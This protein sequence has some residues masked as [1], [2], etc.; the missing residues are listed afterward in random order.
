MTAKV[1]ICPKKTALRPYR[2]LIS[3]IELL[4]SWKSV[5]SNTTAR[6]ENAN[7]NKFLKLVCSTCNCKEIKNILKKDK[8]NAAF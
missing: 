7:P 1:G 5:T 3:I 2:H 8:S 6:Q 4:D